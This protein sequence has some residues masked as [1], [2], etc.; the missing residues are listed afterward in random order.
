MCVFIIFIYFIIQPQFFPPFILYYPPSPSPTPILFSQTVKLPIGVSK[1]C[2]IKLKQD[3]AP[4]LY[5][6]ENKSFFVY[7]LFLTHPDSSL[8]SLLIS[9]SPTYCFQALCLLPVSPRPIL[10]PFLFRKRAYLIGT[11]TEYRIAR[12]NKTR[13]QPSYK[14]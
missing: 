8:S 11:S 3:Q 5:I 7:F 9:Q 14:A 2:H 13:H 1:D 6:K 12:Y 4:L 10:L